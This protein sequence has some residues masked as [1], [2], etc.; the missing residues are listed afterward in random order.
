MPWNYRVVRTKGGSG[1]TAL[2]IR[3]AYYPDGAAPDSKPTSIADE[4]VKLVVD[5]DLGVQSLQND[6]D[7]MQ[8]ALAMSI[9]N[10]S[11]YD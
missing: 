2:E 5:E 8:R 3:T 11:D 1:W 6:L 9:I 10:A 4:P 7:K